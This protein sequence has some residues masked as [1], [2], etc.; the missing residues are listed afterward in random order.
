MYC[1]TKATF[2]HPI[3][4]SARHGELGKGVTWRLC[5]FYYYYPLKFALQI[6]LYQFYI[7]SLNYQLLQ[8]F[9]ASTA[10][11]R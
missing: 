11:L 3:K 4:L 1:S 8:G 10:V 9:L 5:Q 2:I 6:P 7:F